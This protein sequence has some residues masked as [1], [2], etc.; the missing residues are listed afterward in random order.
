M[1]AGEELAV[2][3]ELAEGGNRQLGVEL[4]GRGNNTKSQK[5]ITHSA[6]QTRKCCISVYKYI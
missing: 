5:D 2:G 3:G 1:L 4:A 6:H